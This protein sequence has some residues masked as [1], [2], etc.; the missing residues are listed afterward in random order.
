MPSFRNLIP[1]FAWLA[2]ATNA[3][4]EEKRPDWLVGRWRHEGPFGLVKMRLDLN[5]DGTSLFQLQAGGKTQ[6]D[7]SSWSYRPGQLLFWSGKPESSPKD[8]LRWKIKE[9]RPKKSFTWNPDEARAAQEF[10]KVPIP[11]PLKPCELMKRP[12]P[13]DFSKYLDNCMEEL[14]EQQ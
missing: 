1:V 4:S 13:K 8:P 5:R 7:K 6:E 14:L 11:T 3:M 9:G 12:A 2:L 10:R